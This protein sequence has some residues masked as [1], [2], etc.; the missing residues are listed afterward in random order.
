MTDPSARRRRRRD[1]TRC[2]RPSCSS[3]SDP[4]PGESPD[5]SRLGPDAY[6]PRHRRA[7]GSDSSPPSRPSAAL[8]TS[9]RRAATTSA[10]RRATSSSAPMRP[11]SASSSTPAPRR[12]W[13]SR[14][15]CCRSWRR[16]SIRTGRTRFAHADPLGAMPPLEAPDERPRA[17]RPRELR[18]ALSGP[19]TGR[20]RLAAARRRRVDG[21]HPAGSRRG[22]RRLRRGPQPSPRGGHRASR[23]AAGAGGDRPSRARRCARMY[24]A[25]AAPFYIR[26]GTQR[27]ILGRIFGG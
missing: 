17:V 14:S 1:W 2:S 11:T 24:D 22:A 4:R 19:P 8:E 10:C 23:L 27:G 25:T 9:V 5:P 6:P 15:A 18:A 20:A 12:R 3:R 7:A 13:R 21:R 16:A 26:P